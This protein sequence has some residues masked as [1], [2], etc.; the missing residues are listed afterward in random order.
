ST[1]VAFIDPTLKALIQ[2]AISE[3]ERL[4]LGED[5]LVS[6]FEIIY[7]NPKQALSDLA[8]DSNINTGDLLLF[9]S[10]RLTAPKV[11]NQGDVI[12]LITF[13]KPL[14]DITGPDDLVLFTH[15]LDSENK[16]I[17]Q[18]DRLDVPPTSWRENDIFAQLHRIQ[19]PENCPAGRYVIEI[20]AY[21]RTDTSQRL[22]IITNEQVRGGTIILQ[23]IQ[24]FAD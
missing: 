22:P 15:L 9:K 6:W 7:W 11:I 5:D 23:E 18:Q 16:I 3:I 24:V 13:W 17:A 12:D 19:I 14:H 2:P 1:A 10:Y 21:T 20:G 4:R 8:L